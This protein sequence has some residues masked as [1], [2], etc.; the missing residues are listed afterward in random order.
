[1]LGQVRLLFFDIESKRS[2]VPFLNTLCKS[3]I[4]LLTS[5]F[6]R[7]RAFHFV[8]PH[9]TC[10]VHFSMCNITDCLKTGN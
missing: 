10:S 8:L 5:Y 6:Y 7:S 2:P 1:M 3:V 9:S 4:C